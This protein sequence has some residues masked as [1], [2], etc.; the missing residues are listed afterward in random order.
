MG[1]KFKDIYDDNKYPTINNFASY[2]ALAEQAGLVEL[3]G[4]KSGG[5][6]W[7]ALKDV[8]VSTILAQSTRIFPGIQ[9]EPKFLPLVN[10]L[11]EYHRAGHD[12][13]LRSNIGS[14]FTSIYKTYPSISNFAAYAHQAELAGLIVLGG[15]DSGGREWIALNRNPVESKRIGKAEGEGSVRVPENFALAPR[16]RKI[17]IPRRAYH[18][19]NHTS[20]R[21]SSTRLQLNIH[22]MYY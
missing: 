20:D 15:R 19:S 14:K 9:I 2:A 10:L 18:F 17:S 4:E 3:G 8:E 7:I 16:V 21:L 6:E 13:V 22:S 12:T 1:S 5:R 11:D